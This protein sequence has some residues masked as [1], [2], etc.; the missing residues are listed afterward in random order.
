MKYSQEYQCPVCAL[1]PLR[2]E[3]KGKAGENI[4]EWE[5]NRR[6]SGTEEGRCPWEQGCFMYLLRHKHRVMNH[7]ADP[8]VV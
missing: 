7:I 4:V 1:Q 3:D 2:F 6:R 5:E 8:G